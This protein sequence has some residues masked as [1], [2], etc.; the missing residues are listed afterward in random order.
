MSLRMEQALESIA[1]WDLFEG[2]D[3]QDGLGD[4]ATATCPSCGYTGTMDPPVGN[5]PK[6]KKLDPSMAAAEFY[7]S[8]QDLRDALCDAVSTLQKYSYVVDFGEDWVIFTDDSDSY[9]RSE[10]SVGDT[11]SITLLNKTEVHR[12]FVPVA[13]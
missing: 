5:M 7:D 3:A 1:G 13:A 12:V 8:F 2:A 11:G 10:Y 9:W 4:A 6:P